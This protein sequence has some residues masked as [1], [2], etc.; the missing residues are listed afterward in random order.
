MHTY[1]VYT[2]IV[3]LSN[4]IPCTLKN[5]QFSCIVMTIIY[6]SR[7]LAPIYFYSVD[8]HAILWY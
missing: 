2:K 1:N 6:S 4:I 8:S 5:T 3:I 7:V